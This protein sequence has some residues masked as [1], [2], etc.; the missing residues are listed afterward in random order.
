[1][2]P[3]ILAVV[4]FTLTYLIDLGILKSNVKRL[5]KGGDDPAYL[6][7]SAALMLLG[8]L[9]GVAIIFFIFGVLKMN[10]DHYN[11]AA[12]LPLAAAAGYGA[13]YI[14][15]QFVLEGRHSTEDED[16]KA[17]VLKS[18]ACGLVVFLAIM[19]ATAT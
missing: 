13:L 15:V 10:P 11:P 17:I 18:A 16:T 14:P 9:I 4:F 19:F 2:N 12:G 3:W 1:M 7:K 5:A 8:K 6:A